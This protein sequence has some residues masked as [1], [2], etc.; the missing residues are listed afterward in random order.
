MVGDTVLQLFELA[1]WKGR[2]ARG[3]M[4]SD[5]MWQVRSQE[6]HISRELEGKAEG[7]AKV[8]KRS[9]SGGMIARS[10]QSNNES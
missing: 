8:R 1:R 9:I 3:G 5:C 4:L 10:N 2:V 6:V 7:T